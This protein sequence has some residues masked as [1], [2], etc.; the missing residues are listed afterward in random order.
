M[1]EKSFELFLFSDKHEEILH[2]VR[3]SIATK[4]TSSWGDTICKLALDSVKIV[5]QVL[6]DGSVEIDAKRN[7]RIEQVSKRMIFVK[8]TSSV[9]QKKRKQC[10]PQFVSNRCF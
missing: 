10:F 2:I 4:F 9:F 6:E 5:R 7:I 8:P 3:S 1:F